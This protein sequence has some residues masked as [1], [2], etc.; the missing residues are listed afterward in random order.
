[1]GDVT[2]I[3][4][5]HN[6]RLRAAARALEGHRGKNPFLDVLLDAGAD[7]F[8]LPLGSKVVGYAAQERALLELFRSL[9]PLLPKAP[10]VGPSAFGTIVL[11]SESGGTWHVTLRYGVKPSISIRKRVWVE[12]PLG[13]VKPLKPTSASRATPGELRYVTS[14]GDFVALRVA[15]A[16]LHT[17]RG[18]AGDRGRATKKTFPVAWRAEAALERAAAALRAK[19]YRLARV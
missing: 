18:S 9:A 17:R 3:G 16:T 1:M 6:V 15:H 2:R 14:E 19:G 13:S 8:R 11:E 7:E 5:Q 10:R 4:H 12:V